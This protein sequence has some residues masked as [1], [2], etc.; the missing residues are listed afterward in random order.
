MNVKTIV[1]GQ[2]MTN[3]YI[4]S[5]GKCGFVI[6]PAADA[7][8]IYNEIIKDELNIE[9]I[10]ITHAHFDHIEAAQ[11]LKEMTGARI[12]VSE[13]DA[14]ALNNPA[15]NLA[16]MFRASV[17]HTEADLTVND[18]DT[19]EYEGF[20]LKFIS[21]PGHTP[22]SM[23]ILV[24]NEILFSGDTLFSLSV[25]RTDFPGGSF[26]NITASV[27]KLFMLNDD[28]KVFPGHNETTSIGEEKKYNPYVNGD[29]I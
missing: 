4:C 18:G 17:P 3:C 2:V 12:V 23:C 14:E 22:G 11:K 21:T 26:K 15:L 20:L 8:R 16:D 6:D 13:T 10:I 19:I 24:N 1:L 28:I 7:N 9:Y 5:N 29:T 25:G 27:K